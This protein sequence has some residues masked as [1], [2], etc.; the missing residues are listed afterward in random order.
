MRFT[1][2]RL[3]ASAALA[4]SLLTVAASPAAACSCG[5]A[6][7]EEYFG[8]ADVVF[9]GE[10]TDYEFVNDPDGDGISSSADPATWTFSVERVFKGS[11]ATTQAVLS[12]HSGASCGLE[13]TG[14]PPGPPEGRFVV[15]ANHVADDDG[16]DLPEENLV[17]DLC[18]GTRSADEPLALS[19]DGRPPDP[20]VA[21]PIGLPDGITSDDSSGA[22]LVVGFV[23]VGITA[24]VV[25]AALARRSRVG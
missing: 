15:F 21:L 12:P 8:W 4:G 1:I 11:A 25:G 18:G 17:A 9:V 6:T 22:V 19:V 14:I 24:A 16:W 7:D 20:G 10:L 2:V 23:L 5:P 13:I 3:L